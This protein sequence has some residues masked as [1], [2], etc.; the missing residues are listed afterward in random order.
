MKFST[1]GGRKALKDERFKLAISKLNLELFDD[2]PII[3]VCD[4]FPEPFENLKLVLSI[5]IEFMLV[6]ILPWPE[7]SS[8]PI[9]ILLQSRFTTEGGIPIGAFSG[10]PFSAIFL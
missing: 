4:N 1:T 2:F 10:S 5:A 8:P 6:I 3:I 9:L 7:K